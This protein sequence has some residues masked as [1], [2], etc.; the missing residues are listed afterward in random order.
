MSVLVHEFLE[1]VF[2]EPLQIVFLGV[3]LEINYA[4]LFPALT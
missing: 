3:F 2:I 4:H 1:A